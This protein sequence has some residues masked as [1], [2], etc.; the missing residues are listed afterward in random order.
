MK[1]RKR[2]RKILAAA[3]FLIIQLMLSGLTVHAGT[4]YESPYVT[5]S[6]DGRA[7]TF[8][9]ALPGGTADG[10]PSFWYHGGDIVSTGVTS[11]L[12]AVQEGEHY[13]AVDRAGEV[14]VGSW[15][16]ECPYAQ[17]IHNMENYRYFHGIDFGKSACLRPYFSGWLPYCADCGQRLG[18]GLIYG[19]K[20]AVMSVH[21]IDTTLDLYYLCP[22][23]KHLEQG[24][25]MGTHSCKAI[26]FNRY[27]VV[28][29]A[30]AYNYESDVK[31][32]T[33]DSFH[34]YN[35]ETV[36]EGNEVTP[37][38]HLTL[39]GFQREGYC[40]SG[41]NTE[42]DG[43]GIRYMDGAE[44]FNLSTENYD[45]NTGAGIVTL[46]AQ[47]ER[48][49][50]NLVIDPNGG[51]YEGKT[52]NILL[53]QQ[54]G[55][56]YTLKRESLIPPAGYTVSFETNGGGE[57]TAQ[58]S[59]YTFENWSLQ[60]PANGILAESIYLFRGK[61]N[62]TD[63]VK[64]LYTQHPITLPVPERPNHSFGGWY[65]DSECTEPAGDGGD[66]FLPGEDTV[67][68][69]KW[70]DLVLD[71]EN[72]YDANSGRGAVDLFWNQADGR[73]KTYRLYQSLDGIDFRQIYSAEE[74]VEP[75]L[76]DS[77]FGCNG[78]TRTVIVP[79]TGFY[80]LTAAGAQG[81]DYGEYSGGKGGSV[82]GKF[83]LKKGEVLTITVGG[84]DGFNGGGTASSFGNGGGYTIISSD[85][86]GT[87]LIGGGGGGAGSTGDG[88]NGG[89]QIGLMAQNP[90]TFGNEGG[91][92]ASGGG[93]GMV[94]GQGGIL[95]QTRYT[96][97]VNI[98]VSHR[99]S[100]DS[101]NYAGC[102]ADYNDTLPWHGRVYI[103]LGF[104]NGNPD[105]GS[106]SLS[107]NAVISTDGA[108]F[109]NVSTIGQTTLIGYDKRG[110]SRNL[111]TGYVDVSG[112]DRI[113]ISVSAYIRGTAPEGPE[114]SI[115]INRFELIKNTTSDSYGGS[116]YINTKYAVTCSQKS[117]T[118]TGDGKAEIVTL[119]VGFQDSQGLEG[120]SAPDLAAPDT[121]KVCDIK[122]EDAG[123]NA[124]TVSWQKPSDNGTAYYHKAE[125]YEAE[126][127]QPLCVSN[128]T[129]NLLVSGVRGYFYMV[130][131]R[132]DTRITTA[133]AQ[134]DNNLLTDTRITVVLSGTV[135]Y[136][137][138]AAVDVAG[139]L[140]ETTHVRLDNAEV[141]WNLVTEPLYIDSVV[142][143]KDYENVYPA[144]ADRT[145]YVR[146]DEN[147]PFLI[148]YD[149][150]MEGEARENYQINYQ[151]LDSHV[152]DT[153]KSQRYITKL[154]YTVPLSE[155]S[156][157]D[158]GQFGRK[159]EGEN[160]LKSVLYAG[161]TRSENACKNSFYQAFTLNEEL[162]GKTITVIPAAGADWGEE[163]VYSDCER[164]LKNAIRIIGD[165]E[166]PVITG[167]DTLYG[168]ELIDRGY[169]TV[170]LCITAT[171]NL[172][173]VAEFW[174]EIKNTDNFEERIYRGDENGLIQVDITETDA[175]FTG[176]FSVTAHAV[177]N[178]GNISKEM[179][180]MTEFALETRVERILEPHT[181]VFKCGE[182]GILYI[183]TYG[184]AERVEVEF[185]EELT[186][187]YPELNQTFDYSEA[188]LYVRE[189]ELQFMIPLYAP[190]NANYTITVRAYKGDKKL[191]EYP[192]VS[193]M[194][195]YGS[196]L[197]ELRTRLR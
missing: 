42:A 197:D 19:S 176:D 178:V 151:I 31:G 48:A 150:R 68:Y 87:L 28:Y 193:V 140:S 73:N 54:Y 99:Q 58:T 79:Y 57:L 16:V 56:T 111:S 95:Q 72:N 40:F 22:S 183:T 186:V 5:F 10:K 185:P 174:L 156:V 159:T 14:P 121:I 136:L 8:N 46:Y 81:G 9:Q 177:D 171:D 131:E 143:G 170:Q 76:P 63:T 139:N 134:N 133:D 51:S 148:S 60:V 34:M 132:P 97:N 93:G 45:R 35:N 41:W 62:D 106:A 47:W 196:V 96:P 4:L 168:H 52:K 165:G 155:K 69:A 191:E 152:E 80:S 118:Q 119:I 11:R 181:P 24:R 147:S 108:D 90:S 53:R 141:S 184:Y 104:M 129:K 179:C 27:K 38:T 189:E 114:A 98:N 94:G 164:D 1:K 190:E 12:R 105:R 43:S 100:L 65:R 116:N 115:A 187:L 102:G 122:F 172:S 7:W 17:C 153:G 70:A 123:N 154:P 59:T 3:G 83:Y 166:G 126:T 88:G 33:S 163:I 86:K 21:S 61:M 32:Y 145:W 82:T 66:P 138:L 91:N 125:S 142:A 160:I 71:S 194:Q 13:Y 137:H 124:V 195:V 36:F 110:G 25:P 64:A 55:T 167:L 144:P 117:G 107:A 169:E 20:E 85:Q 149:S 67:L 188:P 44:I 173:G 2:M 192:A 157:L 74:A 50:T 75:K 146:T 84:K 6:P 39:N 162:H 161:C 37:D 175:L 101:N 158:A 23:C 180:R 92:N 128:I 26:S 29:D 135:Q 78:E 109:L 18:N 103:D 182:S 30:N 127:E 89:A 120:V 15:K 113:F 77:I 130:D 112:F 49:E